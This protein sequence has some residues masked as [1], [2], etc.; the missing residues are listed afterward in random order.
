[1]EKSNYI[2][3]GNNS[4]CIYK[5]AVPSFLTLHTTQSTQ[6]KFKL[7]SKYTVNSTQTPGLYEL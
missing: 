6:K 7:Y 2:N 5:K 1:M 3:F 4:C